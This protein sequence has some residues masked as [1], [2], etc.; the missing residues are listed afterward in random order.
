MRCELAWGSK[1]QRGR[2]G[3]RCAVCPPAV[4]G[5]SLSQH[6]TQGNPLLSQPRDRCV[7]S[8]GKVQPRGN[9]GVNASVERDRRLPAEENRSSGKLEASGNEVWGITWFLPVSLTRSLKVGAAA[10]G[11]RG[12]SGKPDTLVSND[13]Q[14][15]DTSRAPHWVFLVPQDTVS[16]VIC[17]STGVGGGKCLYAWKKCFVLVGLLEDRGRGFIAGKS[18]SS[19]GRARVLCR[20]F[21]EVIW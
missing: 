13:A 4:Q 3:V 17:D 21:P 14:S 9:E 12:P 19:M 2:D 1:T 10:T 6:L 18:G 5:G 16:S 15:H 8:C 7:S 11:R 20:P